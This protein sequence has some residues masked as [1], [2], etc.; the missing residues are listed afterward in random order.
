M[1][2][3]LIT[4]LFHCMK[5]MAWTQTLVLY[6]H[7]KWPPRHAATDTYQYLMGL[8]EIELSIRS[9]Y[10]IALLLKSSKQCFLFRLEL[11][12]SPFPKKCLTYQLP[13]L[14]CI[15]ILCFPPITQILLYLKY[16]LLAELASCLSLS[17]LASSGLENIQNSLNSTCIRSQCTGTSL[18]SDAHR[19]HNLSF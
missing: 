9:L 16:E 5:H 18:R 3:L 19:F 15:S 14:H 6:F 11:L 7:I 8:I 13:E 12:S 2:E 10:N 1:F 4:K 17:I